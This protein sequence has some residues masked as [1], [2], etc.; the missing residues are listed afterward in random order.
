MGSDDNAATSQSVEFETMKD[1]YYG[2]SLPEG[3]YVPPFWP[4]LSMMVGAMVAEFSWAIW[5]CWDYL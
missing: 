1:G 4:T 5:Y 2:S 3:M